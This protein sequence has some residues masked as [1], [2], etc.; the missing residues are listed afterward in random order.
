MLFKK[1]FLLISFLISCLIA[2]SYPKD[3]SEHITAIRK[4]RWIALMGGVINSGSVIRPDTTLTNKKFN[5]NYAF[6]ISGYRIIRDRLGVGVIIDVAR[7]SEEEL[8]IMES[9]IFNIGPSARYYAANQIHGGAYLQS[10]LMY[11]RFYDR[12]VLQ[13]ITYPIDKVLKGSGP[14]ITFGLGYSY[15][16]RDIVSLE[17]GFRFIHSWLYGES[18]NQIDATSL[19][20]EFRRFSFSFSFGLGILIGK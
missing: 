1:L 17:I 12:V 10:S 5:N 16:F 2:F 18:I 9:E 20:T 19:D 7:S 13:D 15:I 4:G 6:S 14:G 8:V 11:S 3:S